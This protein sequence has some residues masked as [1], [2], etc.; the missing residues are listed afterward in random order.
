[1]G[2][3]RGRRSERGQAQGGAS[4]PRRRRQPRPLRAGPS[5][6]EGVGEEGSTREGEGNRFVHVPPLPADGEGGGEGVGEGAVFS[7]GELG[8]L[9]AAEE[10]LAFH[11][12]S[13]SLFY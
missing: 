11:I 5:S 1:M 9:G 4:R 3:A 8:R 13:L 12:F 10:T 7:C 6:G 2:D